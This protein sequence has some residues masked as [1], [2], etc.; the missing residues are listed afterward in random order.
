MASDNP[1][2]LLAKP[3]G[4]LFILFIKKKKKDFLF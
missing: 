2:T 3:K 1:K 4:F